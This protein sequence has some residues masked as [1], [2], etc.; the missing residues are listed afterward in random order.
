MSSEAK[1]STNQVVQ[2]KAKE[3]QMKG[4]FKE[5]G[6]L[7]A[8]ILSGLLIFGGWLLNNAEINTASITLYILAF[9]IGGF[10]KA[11]EGLEAT[12]KEKELNVELLMFIAAVGSALIGYWTEGAIL[13]FIFALSGALETYTMNRSNKEISSF[14]E[15]QPEEALLVSNGE[16]RKVMVSEL[17]IGNVIFVKPGER[18]PADGVV[19]KGGSSID[20]SAITGESM[21][22][23]KNMGDE[24]FAGTVNITGSMSIQVTKLSADTIFQ[25][26]IN[27]VQTA[28]SEKSPSQLFIER[29]EGAYVK[30]VLA[31]VALMMILPH[32]LFNWSWQETFYRAMVL[33]VV[34]SPCALVA[35]IMPATL[36]AISNGARNG[37]LFKGGVHLENLGS[38][39]AIAS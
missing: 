30:V 3:S 21:P 2:T 29:F 14:M 19:V 35:S 36:S 25:K 5:H 11:K 32:F 22:I 6:E 4:K 1:I 28:Q 15:L 20:E 12:I 8:A 31:V 33:L 16:Q 24:V 38:L 27:L 34:A 9:C 17:E 7:M 37:I 10:A 39:K 26:I 23:Q 18:V 13:I